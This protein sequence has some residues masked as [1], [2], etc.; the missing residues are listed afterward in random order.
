M[1]ATICDKMERRHPHIFGESDHSP[2]W[3]AIKANERATQPDGSALA[4]VT[5]ALPALMRAEK[6]QKR[7]ARAGFDW[8]DLAGPR[9]KVDEELYAPREAA[10]R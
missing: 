5:R 10:N 4:G 7:A 1:I 2:G 3:E 6:L 8:P 9:A